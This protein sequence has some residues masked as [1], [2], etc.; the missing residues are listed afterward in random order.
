MT[1]DQYLAQSRGLANSL[2]E[3]LGITP[4]L[5][6]QWRY[7]RR[8][9]PVERCVEIERATSGAVSRRELRPLDWQRIWPELLGDST[10]HGTTGV[11][12]AR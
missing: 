5:I 7:G 2:A 1:L 10:D 9:V 4:V 3:E 11:V 8:A 6:S 12:L